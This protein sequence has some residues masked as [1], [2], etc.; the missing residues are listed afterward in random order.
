MQGPHGN[1]GAP[2]DPGHDGERVSKIHLPPPLWAN[3]RPKETYLADLADPCVF[4]NL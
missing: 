3:L 4:I 2:G 1:R